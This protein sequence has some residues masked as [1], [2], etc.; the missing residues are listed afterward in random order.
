MRV[1]FTIRVGIDAPTYAQ[2]GKKLDKITDKLEEV[3]GPQNF[4]L[5]SFITRHKPIREYPMEEN[6]E[7]QAMM[8]YREPEPDRDF[9]R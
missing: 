7:A 8:A 4:D 2:A 3:V 5:E 1:M 9:P 6:M